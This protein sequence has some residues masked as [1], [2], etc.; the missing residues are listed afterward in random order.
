MRALLTV[1]SPCAEIGPVCDGRRGNREHL[2]RPRFT[3]PFAKSPIVEVSL[4]S[5]RIGA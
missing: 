3:Q 4:G 1:G 2:A 5:G